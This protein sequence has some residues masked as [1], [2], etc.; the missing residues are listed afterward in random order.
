MGA[1]GAGIFDDDTA[2]DIIGE[3]VDSD[4][5]DYFEQAIGKC[6]KID[7]IEYTECHEIILMAVI[8][9]SIKNGKKYNNDDVN[10]IAE[11][12]KAMNYKKYRD[13]IKALL[14]RVVADKSELNELWLEN[15]E[16]YPKWKAN[17]QAIISSI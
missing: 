10:T 3:I 6:K 16:D 17:I 12:N 1:W 7:Y 14:I 8:V 13:D 5:D 9:D 2:L 15:K 4:L 11:K